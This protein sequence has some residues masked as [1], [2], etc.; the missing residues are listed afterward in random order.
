MVHVYSLMSLAGAILIASSCY[1]FISLRSAPAVNIP[2]AWNVVPFL[3]TEHK[4]TADQSSSVNMQEM[5]VD[6]VSQTSDVKKSTQA[7]EH[8]VPQDSIRDKRDFVLESMEKDT[9]VILLLVAES[10]R[11]DLW[12]DFKATH[13]FPVEGFL[14]SCHSTKIE[15]ERFSL[16]DA[17]ISD[18]KDTECNCDH[19]LKSNVA[20][21]LMWAR[22]VKGMATGT[23]LNSNFTIPSL[24][25]YEEPP[26]VP[27]LD[28]LDGNTKLNVRKAKSEIR[29][30]W[31]LIDLGKPANRASSMMF[32]PNIREDDDSAWNVFDMF[33]RIRMA[34]FRSLLES[35]GGNAGA[36]EDPGTFGRSHRMPSNLA[37]IVRE[38]KSIQNQKGF[39]L[40]AATPASELNSVMETLQREVSEDVL[41]AI[42]G[43]CTHD[44]KP[45][46]F[47][48]SGPGA[49]MLHVAITVWDLPTT[50]RNIL[51][52][53][54]K[55]PS[56]R[57][58]QHELAPLSIAEH[59]VTSQEETVFKRP[60]RDTAEKTDPE[61]KKARNSNEKKEIKDEAK[62]T[63]SNI[64]GGAISA[65]EATKFTA[66]FGT[67]ASTLVTFILAS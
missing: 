48:A 56:C 67:I 5:N 21:L 37:D 16:G 65:I 53:G 10:G 9:N 13:S 63:P 24:F 58:R 45:I 62:G 3:E 14:Q 11:T 2:P 51:A 52:T 42:T 47:F 25:G 41:V 38:L 29:P 31:Y 60:S 39:I 7:A 22:D 36:S 32:A 46:P 44:A 35:L 6:K 54:C 17:L 23:L 49:K 19:Y 20:A 30:D 66:I 50:I 18:N 55:D 12:K 27:E 40:V 15:G 43:V 59:K 26:S 61:T 64:R 28:E 57:V 33:S 34:L 4:A 8:T 1:A